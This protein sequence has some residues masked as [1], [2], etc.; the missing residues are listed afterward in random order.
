MDPERAYFYLFVAPEHRRKGA[1]SLLYQDML[2]SIASL[3]LKKLRVSVWDN[4]PGGRSFADKRGFAER[5]HQ[6]AMQLDLRTFDDT[7]YQTVI[8]R[9]QGEGFRFTSTGELG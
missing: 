4:C 5:L 8:D 7:P 6:I 3:R 2:Q 1:G 9:L